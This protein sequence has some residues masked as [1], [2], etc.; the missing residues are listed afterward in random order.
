MHCPSMRSVRSLEWSLF[1]GE[2]D[3]ANFGIFLSTVRHFGRGAFDKKDE[4]HLNFGQ[5]EGKLESVCFS[6]SSFH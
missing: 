3:F 5:I 6:G 4:Q 2:L 1:I